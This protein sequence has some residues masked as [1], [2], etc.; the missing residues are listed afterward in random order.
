MKK[1][2]LSLSVIAIGA[3]L[4]NAKPNVDNSGFHAKIAKVAGEKG[5][6]G[7]KEDFPKDYFL[8]PKNLPY[9]V[10]YSLHHPQSSSLNLSKDQL[11]KIKK[12]KKTTVPAVLK[13]AKAIKKLELE[14]E[15]NM[16]DKNV[17]L[18]AQYPLL[19]KIAKKRVELSK[20]HLECIKKVRNILTDKQFETLKK[21]MMNM[22]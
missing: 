18:K 12:V 5:V 13:M 6:F 16:E 21:Y 20:A 15:K 1:I 17:D 8:V 14:L 9:L 22:R 19:E 2:I 10:G 7:F 11:Q 4:A 3:S